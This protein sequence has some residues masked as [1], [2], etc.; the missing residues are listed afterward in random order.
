MRIKT[1]TKTEYQQRINVLVEYINNHLGEDI[2]LNKLAEISGFSR[3][4]FHR[5]FAEFLGEPVGTFI[6]RMRVETA[7]RLLRYTE[8][9]VK[10]IAYKVGYDVPSS[11]SKVF[12]QFYGISPNEY[13]NNKDYVIFSMSKLRNVSFNQCFLRGGGLDN[14]QFTNVEFEHCNLVEA[15]FHRTSLKGIDLTS[16]EIAGIRIGSIPGGELKGATVTSLQALDIAR[17]L[18]ITIKD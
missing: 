17:M 18:G 16:S 1:T 9:P 4:H 10:E 8:I 15:E 12:R 2:D 13:R 6:V 11:L 7:A 5:I 3:W 14:C